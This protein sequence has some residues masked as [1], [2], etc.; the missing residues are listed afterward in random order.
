M[1]L[2]YIR[3]KGNFTDMIWCNGYNYIIQKCVPLYVHT[4]N[5]ATLLDSLMLQSL[6]IFSS[7]HGKLRLRMYY[8]VLFKLLRT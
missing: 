1:H 7:I 4:E 2:E 5:T 6:L 3:G 8:S